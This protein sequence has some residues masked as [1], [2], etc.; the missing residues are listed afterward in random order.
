[1][2]LT[3]IEVAISVV[4]GSLLGMSS[5]LT[6]KNVYRSTDGKYSSSCG[7]PIYYKRTNFSPLGENSERDAK[8]SIELSTA[9]NQTIITAEQIRKVTSSAPSNE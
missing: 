6:R 9:Q 7:A 3:M 5:V 8:S 2:V 4:V 1:M